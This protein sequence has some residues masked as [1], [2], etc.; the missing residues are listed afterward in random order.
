MSHLFDQPSV[1]VIGAPLHASQDGVAASSLMLA[2]L[3]RELYRGFG[4]A[5]RR[6][7]VMADEAPRL[8]DRINFEEVSSVARGAGVSLVV[9][10]QFV[11]QFTDENQRNT[12]IGNCST[13]VCMRT[14]SEVSAD[15]F[16]SRLGERRHTA[17]G[18]SVQTS[19]WRTPGGRQWSQSIESAPVLG[20]REIMDQPWSDFPALVH[21][22]QLSA[23]PFAVDLEQRR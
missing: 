19:T 12:I 8:A 11:E 10:A 14:P 5:R 23:A 22:T 7:V 6:V 18:H 13:Y 17:L 15:H 1:L 2:L 4:V 9:A 20:R 16:A 21:S 3:F